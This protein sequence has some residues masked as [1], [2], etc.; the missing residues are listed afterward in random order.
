MLTRSSAV[1]AL[2][3]IVA[4]TGCGGP[5]RAS[6]S[7]AA[8]PKIYGTTARAPR[9]A[10]QTP[11]VRSLARSWW[12]AARSL[13]MCRPPD[14]ALTTL[15]AGTSGDLREQLRTAPPRPSPASCGRRVPLAPH[16][17]VVREGAEWIA[18]TAAGHGTENT[19]QLTIKPTDHGLRVVAWDY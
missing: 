17:V 3:G 14:D 2:T 15:L 8:P 9:A 10:D 11:A 4:L 12:V 5:N 16:V 6:G 13:S 7:G 18:L 1:L 19:E